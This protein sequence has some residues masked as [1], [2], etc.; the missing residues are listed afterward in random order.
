[1]VYCGVWSTSI[2]YPA[3][4]LRNMASHVFFWHVWF[5]FHLKPMKRR[6]EQGEDNINENSQY[7]LKII[8]FWYLV[9]KKKEKRFQ[10]RWGWPF[11][12]CDQ[13]NITSELEEIC[14]LYV[15]VSIKKSFCASRSE[16]KQCVLIPL[17]LTSQAAP[18]LKNTCWSIQLDVPLH[19]LKCKLELN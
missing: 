3:G 19:T 6:S 13:R 7:G 12:A 8:F 1:M 17:T 15:R 9:K 2:L 11:L 16:E 4:R 5:L 14:A 18:L 10:R